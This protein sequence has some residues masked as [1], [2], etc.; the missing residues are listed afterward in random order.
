MTELNHF[1][2]HDVSGDDLEA[3]EDLAA[4]KE[5]AG[6]NVQLFMENVHAFFDDE[7]QV[8]RDITI[9]KWAMDRYKMD[10]EDSCP[11]NDRDMLDM[12]QVL[13]SAGKNLP[14][15]IVVTSHGIVRWDWEPQQQ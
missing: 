8:Y 15:N 11:V 14:D 7:C 1:G 3:L 12:E 10:L 2:F 13:E 6:E 9:T 5:A 4:L